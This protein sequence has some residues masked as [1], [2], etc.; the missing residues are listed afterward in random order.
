MWTDFGCDDSFHAVSRT[1]VANC[2]SGLQL[3]LIFLL[4]SKNIIL[5]YKIIIYKIKEKEHEK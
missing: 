1:S 2:L 3:P 4:H 5:I